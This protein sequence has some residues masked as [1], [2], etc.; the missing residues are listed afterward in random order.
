M[1]H[2]AENPQPPEYRCER[3][4][5]GMKGEKRGGREERKK[6]KKKREVDK[7]PDHTALVYCIVDLMIATV[8][9]W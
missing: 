9:W 3:V 1:V 2:S 4:G 7:R 6:R 8:G 5:K